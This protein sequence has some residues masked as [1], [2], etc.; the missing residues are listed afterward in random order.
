MNK[1]NIILIGMPG[2][3]KS[4]C[5]VLA[6]KA[7]LKKFVD[8]DLII[9][10]NEGMA[11]QEILNRR[12]ADYFLKAEENALLTLQAENSVI[13]TG[14][15]AVFSQKGMARLAQGA[16]IIY[17]HIEYAEMIRRINN[18]TT[19]GVVLKN[20]ETP[21]QMFAERLPL[22]R[23]TADVTIDC[24]HLSVENTVKE[25]VSSAK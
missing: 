5:G 4:T 1:Q 25:I 9:Q 14:G 3:G 15:S 19:R 16:K 6:A 7:L 24:T 8:T 11:L 13:A 12:G 20:G 23:R 22:Y 18:I 2:S 10:Q 21:A 17:L